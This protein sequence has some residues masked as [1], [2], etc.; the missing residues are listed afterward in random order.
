MDADDFHVFNSLRLELGEDFMAQELY[1]A[2]RGLLDPSSHNGLCLKTPDESFAEID[3]RLAQRKKEREHTQR[4]QRDQAQKNFAEEEKKRMSGIM[5][6]AACALE[7]ANESSSVME[8]KVQQ[9]ALKLETEWDELRRRQKEE[10]A[11][12]K[13]GEKQLEFPSHSCEGVLSPPGVNKLQLE[14]FRGRSELNALWCRAVVEWALEVQRNYRLHYVAG[15]ESR[16]RA[17][18]EDYERQ[19]RKV[20]II[21]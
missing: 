19:T 14:E 20:L 10:V 11:A 13:N 4:V 7:R 6:K 16:G 18:L 9:R 8:Q 15:D 21:R 1:A 2:C 12:L 17:D 5:R 3:A